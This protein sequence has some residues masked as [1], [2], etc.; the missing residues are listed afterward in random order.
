M[1]SRDKRVQVKQED[2]V[3]ETNFCI[4]VENREGNVFKQI[5]SFR[6]A[7]SASDFELS[8]LSWQNF[9]EGKVANWI[10]RMYF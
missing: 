6:K 4:Y 7:K 10:C 2:Y 9:V 1:Q 5:Q 3:D 8:S